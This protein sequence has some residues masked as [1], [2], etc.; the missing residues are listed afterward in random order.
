MRACASARSSA[1][2]G[3]GHQGVV[4]GRHL[5]GR[6]QGAGVAQ[7]RVE[8]QLEQLVR[9]V[10]V[11]GDVAPCVGAGA[12]LV[13]RRAHHGDRAESLQA[14]GDQR[15]HVRG[16]HLEEA[17]EVVRVPRAG[18]VGLAEPD[19]HPA[20]E[21]GEEL[22]RAMHGHRRPTGAEGPAPQVD[23][24]REPSYAGHEEAAGH[25]GGDRRT[26][27]GGGAGEIGP[28]VERRAAE[29]G[30]HRAVSSWI[31]RASQPERDA[32]GSDQGGTAQGGRSRPPGRGLGTT[33]REGGAEARTV[34]GVESDGHGRSSPG[35]GTATSYHP[36]VPW[37]GET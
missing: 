13:A 36:S 19:Q 22:L 28:Q 10:V 4:V 9:Q 34:V 27:A 5:L 30:R 26:Q 21:P 25:G 32:V 35:T 3:R 6:E 2:L 20:A 37:N 1:G 14:L 18:Q 12:A 17:A 8:E 31:G 24:D 15:R 11:M 23:G 33:P 16:Q 7:A 29:E